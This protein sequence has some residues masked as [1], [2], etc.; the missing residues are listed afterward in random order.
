M[1]LN[2][3]E[4][5][6]THIQIRADIFF[7]LLSS[8]YHNCM[9]GSFYHG[10]RFKMLI[11]T[12]LSMPKISVPSLSFPEFYRDVFW[13]LDAIELQIS[14]SLFSKLW[15]FLFKRFA[16]PGIWVKSTI[17]MSPP[18]NITQCTV[19][20]GLKRSVYGKIYQTVYLALHLVTFTF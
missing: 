12:N 10:I 14:L 15:I 8:K 6:H 16:N 11:H 18:L 7:F 3:A 13:A 17:S 1:P 19:R 20:Y 2:P 5:Q 9:C 4:G